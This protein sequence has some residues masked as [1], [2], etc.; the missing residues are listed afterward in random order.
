MDYASQS[1][2]HDEEL[3]LFLFK[4]KDY[5]YFCVLFTHQSGNGSIS[6]FQMT[7]S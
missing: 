6:T 4:K 3:C 2:N 5:K 1:L 7:K